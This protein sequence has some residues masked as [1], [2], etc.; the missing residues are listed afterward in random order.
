MTMKI[1]FGKRKRQIIFLTAFCLLAMLVTAANNVTTEL[2][3]RPSRREQALAE[4]RTW[5][6]ALAAEIS[7]RQDGNGWRQLAEVQPGFFIQICSQPAVK[8]LTGSDGR[9]R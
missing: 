9:N 3:T 5:G 2:L 4:M 7:G 1:R 8:V 6:A